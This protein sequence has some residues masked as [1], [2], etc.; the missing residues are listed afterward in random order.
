[1]WI[2]TATRVGSSNGAWAQNIPEKDTYID[3]LGDKKGAR[4]AYGGQFKLFDGATLETTETNHEI[5]NMYLRE[6][7]DFLKSI[8]T[9]E[10]TRNHI[11]NILETMKLLNALYD[12]SDAKA[13]LKL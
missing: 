10:V 4:L 11:E 8:D 5:P 7:A 1:M 12:S 6:D 13:E 2:S 3:F 9:G